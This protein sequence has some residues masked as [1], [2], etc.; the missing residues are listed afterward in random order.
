[1]KLFPVLALLASPLCAQ[2]TPPPNLCAANPTGLPALPASA[3]FPLPRSCWQPVYPAPSVPP[4]V[5]GTFAQLQ[6]A[7]KAV[8]CGGYIVVKAGVRYAGNLIYPPLA[9]PPDN[10]VLIENSA[11]NATVACTAANQTQYPCSSENIGQTVPVFP[12][13]QTAN[14]NL[15]G[16][17]W[18]PVLTASGNTAAMN[19]SDGAAG[20]FISGLGFTVCSTCRA[21]PIVAMGE[22]APAI[23]LLPHHIAFYNVFVTPPPCPA[24]SVAAPCNHVVRGIDLN[25]VNGAVIYSAVWGIVNPAFDA[26][27]ILLNNTPGPSLVA[28]NYLSA[29]GETL[30]YNT[31]CTNNPGGVSPTGA[32]LGSMGFEAGDIGISACPAPAD[33]TVTGNYF[34]KFRGWQSLPAGCSAQGSMNDLAI[35]PGAAQLSSV[36]NPFTAAS[37]DTVLTVS[38]TP[39]FTPGRYRVLSVSGT[40]AAMSAAIGAVG[41]AAGQGTYS[42]CYDVKNHIEVKHGAYILEDSNVMDTTYC[43]GQCEAVIS[44]CFAQGI[45]VCEYET[46]TNN[47]IMHAPSVGAFSGNGAATPSTACGATGQPACT[48]AAGVGLFYRNNL[49]IDINGATWG[50]AGCNAATGVGCGNGISWQFQNTNGITG[51]HNTT[52]NYVPLYSN[53]LDFSD[54]PPSTNLNFWWTNNIQAFSPF[55]NGMSPGQAIAAL[56]SPV[57]GGNIFVADYWGYPNANGAPNTPAY[58]AGISSRASSAIPVAGKASCQLPNF[59]SLQCWGLDWALLGFVDF[60]NGNAGTNIPGMALSPSSPYKGKGTDGMDPGVNM[61]AFAAAIGPVLAMG[62]VQT[63]PERVAAPPKRPQE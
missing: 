37:V 20:V 43:G 8:Q 42:R 5:V 45:Y 16:S 48:V 62:A 40:T 33:S 49:A 9:C 27:A 46:L 47:L 50:G 28:R 2:T 35:G 26:Q 23:A 32:P 11:I 31:S 53:G 4:V 15:W 44:N 39:G 19:I 54:Q 12:R 1:M 34:K 63:G 52:V 60:E 17:Q 10:M 58:P 51:D 25:A 14:I 30:M 61:P 6:A 21:Y 57:F 3:V 36:S 13:Y 7:V 55:A 41:S 38:N 59:P 18:I 56:P 22:T 29:S 24:D